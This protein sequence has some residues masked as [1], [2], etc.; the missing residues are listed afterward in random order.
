ML[1]LILVTAKKANANIAS[2]FNELK[3]LRK[4]VKGQIKYDLK[5]YGNVILNDKDH[6]SIW[7]FIRNVTFTT[8]K[9]QTTSMDPHLLNDYFASVVHDPEGNECNVPSQPDVEDVFQIQLP[10]EVEIIHLLESTESKSSAGHDGLPG[11]IIKNFASSLGPSIYEV[12][13]ASINQNTFPDE[14]KKSNVCAIWKNKG[15]KSDPSNYRPISII[16]IL[17]RLLEKVVSRQLTNFCDAYNVIPKE[18]F[19][20]RKNSSCEI[21][22]LSATDKWLNQIDDGNYVGTLLI[23]LTKAFD[24][25]SHHQLLLELASIHCGSN[26]LH[27]FQ[28]YLNERQQ[29]V[30]TQDIQTPWK[31][32]SRGI[33]RAA[34]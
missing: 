11:H 33:L 29:R 6:H 19:G 23:D 34:A 17:G 8:T 13:N 10:S 2:Q 15:K 9:S 22:L 3:E 28:S 1:D 26:S 30:V 18:Q 31:T 32:V 5:H 25:V 7:R 4:K 12:F 16:P 27:W 14:W 20:F 24:S 21:A